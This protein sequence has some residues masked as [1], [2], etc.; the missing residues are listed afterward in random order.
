MKLHQLKN[1]ITVLSALLIGASTDAAV[2]AKGAISPGDVP[3]VKTPIDP[4]PEL[5]AYVKACKSELGFDTIPKFSCEGTR[6]RTASGGFFINTEDLVGHQR[7]NDEVNA[8]F[9]CRWVFGG[10]DTPIKAATGEM[11]IHN[12]TNGKTCFFDMKNE[13][14]G[15]SNTP[16]ISTIFPSMPD[17]FDAFR[18]WNTPDK[19]ASGRCTTCHSAGPWIAS[20]PIV[21]HL[22]KFGLI[23]D[24]HD[25]FGTFYT[26]I[27]ST[28]AALNKLASTHRDST[29]GACAAA[30]HVLGGKT[31]SGTRVS[32]V[33]APPNSG[34][35]V[36]PSINIAIDELTGTANPNGLT[37]LE[38]MPPTDPYSDYRW[39]NRDMPNGA[40][41]YERMSDV[42]SEYPQFA[43]KGTPA[44]MQVR[45]VDSS[46]FM[47]T[48]D[49]PDVLYRFNLQ[50]GLICRNVDQ[51]DGHRCTDYETRYHCSSG[52]S[53]WRNTGTP[54]K[55]GEVES[56]DNYPN[57]CRNPTE[58]Q[59]RT[60]DRVSGSGFGAVNRLVKFDRTGLVCRNADQPS[61]QCEDYTVRFICK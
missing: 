27:G 17:E 18:F 1:A 39:I 37:E 7:I 25:T 30:C 28:G 55:T 15:I 42:Q 50:D 24:G 14:E 58:I 4:A 56:R 16:L 38:H 59:A 22:A 26:A 49:F 57:L 13:N 60:T 12:R 48:A 3:P 34:I 10:G 51:A 29:L 46:R 40:G 11:I 47:S 35:I 36:I 8:V 45:V 23:N 53:A 41:D 2:I 31:P 19:T 6:F 33:V 32:S 52:W 9:A 61:G 21:S 54:D 20:S 5:T 44:E 43:C